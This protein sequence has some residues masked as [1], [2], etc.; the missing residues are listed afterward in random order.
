MTRAMRAVDEHAAILPYLTAA[1]SGE[2]EQPKTNFCLGI[3]PPK[4]I[5]G[6]SL[7]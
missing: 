6:L 1:R 7:L 2:V 5:F 4:A 3:M